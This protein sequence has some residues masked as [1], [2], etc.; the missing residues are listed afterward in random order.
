MIQV[1]NRALD[2]VRRGVQREI[3]GHRAR[4]SDPLLR[5]RELLLSGAE[6]LT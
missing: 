3:L 1:T 4:K 6:R 5:I 2:K